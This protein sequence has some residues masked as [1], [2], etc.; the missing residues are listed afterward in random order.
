MADPRNGGPKSL[1]AGVIKIKIG[2]CKTMFPYIFRSNLSHILGALLYS[3]L[4]STKL[5]MSQV[6]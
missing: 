2:I 6:S 3:E 4:A 5:S 1:V